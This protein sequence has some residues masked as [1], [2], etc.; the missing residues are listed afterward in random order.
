M[1]GRGLIETITAYGR[2]WEFDGANN[3]LPGSGALLS[4]MPRF[5]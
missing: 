1:P 4:S 5:R 2:Y 3:P